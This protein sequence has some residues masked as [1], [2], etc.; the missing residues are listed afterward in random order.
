MTRRPLRDAFVLVGRAT[1]LPGKFSRLLDGVRVVDRVLDATRASGYVPTIVT[2]D[3][4]TRS[5]VDVWTDRYDRGPLGGVRTIVEARAGPFL[6]VGGDMPFLSVAA[7]RRLRSLFAP[8]RSVVPRWSDGTIEVLHAV[9]DL[10]V[11]PVRRAWESGRS[12]RDLVRERADSGE[13]RFVPAE[14]FEPTTFRDID[15]PADWARLARGAGS[16]GAGRTSVRR[17]RAPSPHPDGR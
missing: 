9:Y 14:S 17:E 15:T 13:V 3:P 6:L 5:G 10:E 16:K 11:G 4:R 7:L 1:R 2:T 12:L 8:G